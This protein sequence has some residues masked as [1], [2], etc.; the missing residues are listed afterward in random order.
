MAFAFYNIAIW[1]TWPYFREAN[2]N[3]LFTRL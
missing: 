3:D 1:N 2:T